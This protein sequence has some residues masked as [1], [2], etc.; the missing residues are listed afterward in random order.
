MFVFA[1]MHWFNIK[2]KF[3]S[4]IKQKI[5]QTVCSCFNDLRW[6]DEVCYKEN[7]IVESNV[8]PEFDESFYDDVFRGVHNGVNFEII[9]SKFTRGYGKNK[10]DLFD[11]VII[12]LDMNKKNIG[13]TCITSGF[14]LNKS[15]LSHLSKTE[16]EDV[17][18]EKKFDVYT[19]DEVEARYLITP[20]FME[21]L[22]RI[23]L[24]FKTSNM[25]CTFYDKYIVLALSTKR[26]LFSLCSLVRPM[27]DWKPYCQMYE[28]IISIIKL[29]DHFKLEQKIG[30]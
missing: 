8:L 12:L 15:N 14:I 4:K 20:S 29:I 21:R 23:Q 2:K 6:H 11:G 28:E 16:L 30:L 25:R 1:F 5:M 27:S 13:E 26:D 18:F 3:E 9:E 19:N 7:I 17:Q 24:A 22:K 10:T